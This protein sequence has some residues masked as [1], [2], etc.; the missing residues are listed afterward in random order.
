MF[1][2]IDELVCPKMAKVLK[3]LLPFIGLIFNIPNKLYNTIAMKLNILLIFLTLS[4]ITKAN[5]QKFIPIEN[6]TTYTIEYIDGKEWVHKNVNGFSVGITCNLINDE[7]GEYYQI[8]LELGNSSG[9]SY[10]FDPNNVQA[11]FINKKNNVVIAKVFSADDFSQIIKD[12]NNAL[13]IN[14]NL[15]A[16]AAGVE[17]KQETHSFLGRTYTIETKE[18]NYSKSA[19]AQAAAAT[20]NSYIESKAHK[21]V[22]EHNKGYLKKNTIHNGDTLSGYMNI[23]IKKGHTLNV[24][25]PIGDNKLT[26]TWSLSNK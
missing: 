4:F 6:D 16:V 22:E 3:K 11:F 13:I 25:V 15:S 1:C 2:K 14:N 5:A 8:E 26:Y 20:Q 21:D 12:K 10:L 18:F 7:Y 9:D 24:I 23:K 17:K 19:Q